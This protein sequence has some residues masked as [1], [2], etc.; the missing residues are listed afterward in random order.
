M[1]RSSLWVMNEKYEGKRVL[2]FSNSWLF[3]PIVWEVLLD[4]Y[5][6]NEIQTPYGYKKSLILNHELT[7]P[8]NEK[9]NSCNR[10][11]DRICWEM[12]NQQ[13]FFTRDKEM[14]AQNIRD[15]I[16]LNED[17]D[18]DSKGLCP[19]KGEHI[20]SRFNEIADSI[21][22]LNEGE[23][24]YFIFKCTSCDDGVEFWFS[25]YDEEEDKYRR[26]SL[27]EVDK[28]VTEFVMID[29]GIIEGFQSNVK[30]F[31]DCGVD[32]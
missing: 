1:S 26:R 32:D 19:L 28:H 6:H 2:E 29:N 24:P 13:T 11:P 30:Y 23:A 8:L 14:V 5:M 31:K 18:M 12:S 20:I 16:T 25:R 4:K 15:F 3:S 27:D 21:L 22:C 9:I 17:F 10:L 7:V